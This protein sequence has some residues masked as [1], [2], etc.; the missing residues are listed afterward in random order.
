MAWEK[1]A[2]IRRALT[3]KCAQAG[4]PVSGT[5]ELTPRCNLACRMCYIRLTPEQMAPIGRE[6]SAKEWLD[7]AQQAKDA[8]MTFLLLTGGEPTLRADF[9]EIYDKK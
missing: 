9:L 5:F 7:I 6:R 8:G 3:L 4:I 1:S 2:N